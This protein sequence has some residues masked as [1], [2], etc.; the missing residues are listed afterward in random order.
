M[1]NK[2]EQQSG[3]LRR[4]RRIRKKIFGVVSKP[5]MSVYR[6]N[7][8]IYV[9]VVDDISGRTLASASSID[10][11]A[12][13][14]FKG[15]DKKEQAKAVGKL[16]AQRALQNGLEEVVFDRNGFIYHGRVAAVAE[17]AREGGLR[18]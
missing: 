5:R 14:T 1:Q 6:S 17:G 4:K 10:H 18:F 9:Q 16:L 8:A 13:E 12:R 11:D 7:K 15:L 3:R 2:T